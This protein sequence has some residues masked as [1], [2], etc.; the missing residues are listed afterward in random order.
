[1]GTFLAVG[2]DHDLAAI[3][4]VELVRLVHVLAPPLGLK[5]CVSYATSFSVS[6]KYKL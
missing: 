6:H 1:V 3:T 2:V 4:P 5:T